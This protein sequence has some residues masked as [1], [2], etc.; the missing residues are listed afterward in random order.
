MILTSP[1]PL[2][3]PKRIISLV[4]SQT[5]LLSDLGLD[6]EV[7]GIT[8]FCN[9]PVNWHKHKT[10]VGGTKTLN[11]PLIRELKPDLI[12]ANKEENEKSQIEALQNEA[13]ILVT[14]V[15]SLEEAI[16]M[17]K[18]VGNITGKT[19]EAIKLATSILAEFSTLHSQDH[20]IP[21][22]YLIWQKPYMAAGGGTFIN[23]MM[24]QCGLQNIFSGK[25]RYP[26]ITLEELDIGNAGGTRCEL[27]ILAS[28]PYPFKG[29]HLVEI[30]KKLPGLKIALADGEMFSWYGSRLKKAPAY[31]KKIMMHIRN[32]MPV[33]H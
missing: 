33:S 11:I 9:H 27:L 26:E 4:P 28:E 5:E 3:Q 10:K 23:D 7:I 13:N 1:Y 21:A 19:S 24:T 31:F 18:D 29:K 2:L 32:G 14:D 17:I 12:I 30:Q 25:D 22:A 20:K 6:E 16:A 15:S 8:K